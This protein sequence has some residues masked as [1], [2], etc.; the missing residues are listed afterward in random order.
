[1]KTLELATLCAFNI[2]LAQ[3]ADNPFSYAA[4]LVWFF[5]SGGLLIAYQ[6][7]RRTS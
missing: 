6:Q 1:M 5:L 2:V 3:L 7:R 4:L